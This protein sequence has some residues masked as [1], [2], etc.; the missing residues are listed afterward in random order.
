[1][2]VYILKSCDTCRRAVKWLDAEGIKVRVFDI[3]IDGISGD[4][5]KA[6]IAALGW[7]KVLNRRSTSWRTLDEGKKLDMDAE[8]ALSRISDNPTLMKRP[9]F[10]VSESFVVGFDK[11]AQDSLMEIT[12]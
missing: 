9:L 4:V 11:S 5:I 1:M 3:R 2:E 7:E 8:K 12:S 6:A 10:V